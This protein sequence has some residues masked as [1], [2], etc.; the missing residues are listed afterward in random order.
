MH[1][2][3]NLGRLMSDKTFIIEHESLITHLL[4]QILV[5]ITGMVGKKC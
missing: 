1:K 5:A 2:Y 4:L 3:Y